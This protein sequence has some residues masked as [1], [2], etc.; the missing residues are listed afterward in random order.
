MTN[1]PRRVLRLLPYRLRAYKS[2]QR[3]P[4]CP[5]TTPP[6][7][8]QRYVSP[9]F[10][11]SLSLFAF[12][13]HDVLAFTEGLFVFTRRSRSLSHGATA[14]R[15]TAAMSRRRARGVIKRGHVC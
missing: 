14:T 11:A 1:T 3:Y 4:H 5:T 10:N 7:D 6:L 8:T 2:C 13:A 15:V 12:V 9:G